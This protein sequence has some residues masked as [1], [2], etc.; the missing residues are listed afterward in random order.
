[1]PR[2]RC[3]YGVK[4]GIRSA[5]RTWRTVHNKFTL[6]KILFM[7]MAYQEVDNILNI[8]MNVLSVIRTISEVDIII[9]TVADRK[10][11]FKCYA[12]KIDP[13]GIY[14]MEPDIMSMCSDSK[15]NT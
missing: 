10:T 5:I 2:L 4:D 13:R 15:F 1:M 8:F 7:A 6:N 12:L 3:L 11:E 14:T 9:L